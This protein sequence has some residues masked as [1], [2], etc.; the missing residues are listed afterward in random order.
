MRKTPVNFSF[1]IHVGGVEKNAG[2]IIKNESK[3]TL[4]NHLR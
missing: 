2:N 1:D 4:K 3:L